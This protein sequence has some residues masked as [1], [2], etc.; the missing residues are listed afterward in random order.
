MIPRSVTRLFDQRAEPRIEP[1]EDHG[2]LEHRGRRHPVNV[3]NLSSS[4]AMVE[5]ETVPHIGERVRLQLL[6]REPVAGFVRWVRDGRIGVNF[7]VPFN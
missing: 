2:V 5:Y 4:G 1:D 7:D 3:V 6:G